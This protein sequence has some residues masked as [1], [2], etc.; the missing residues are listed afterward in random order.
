MRSQESW[1]SEACDPWGNGSDEEEDV[2]LEGEDDLQ[3]S[4]L[5]GTEPQAACLAEDDHKKFPLVR[6]RR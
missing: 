5:I 2:L 1:C 3:A 6:K 4:P